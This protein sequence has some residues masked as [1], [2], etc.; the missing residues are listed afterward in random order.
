MKR[1]LITAAWLLISLRTLT[2]YGLPHALNHPYNLRA[3]CE[4]DKDEKIKA[5]PSLDQF[6]ICEEYTL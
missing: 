3:E 6:Q 5:D 4:S 1:F 2:Q